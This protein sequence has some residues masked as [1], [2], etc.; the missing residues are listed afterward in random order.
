MGFGL[1]DYHSNK[2]H[3]QREGDLIYLFLIVVIVFQVCLSLCY[4]LY[5]M[6]GKGKHTRW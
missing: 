4:M 1:V 5:N 6:L 2:K 3:T